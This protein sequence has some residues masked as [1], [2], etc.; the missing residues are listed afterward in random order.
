MDFPLEL[1]HLTT[2]QARAVLEGSST[3]VVLVPVGSTEPHGPHLPLS[4]DLIIS[5]EVCRRAASALRRELVAAFVAPVLPYGVTDFAAGF[6]GAISIPAATLTA[7]VRDLCRAYLRDGW[8][9]VSVVNNH[10][11][12]EH[13]A[14]LHAAV[15]EVNEQGGGVDGGGIV[16]CSLPNVLSRRWGRTLTEEFKRGACHAGRYEGSLVLAARPE[17][18]DVDVMKGLPEN[19][20][21][22]SD[23]IASG[24]QTFREIGGEEAYFG[25]PAEATAAEGEDT[26]ARLVE[27]VRCEVLEALGR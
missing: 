8:R 9:H 15:V 16:P 7:F 20:V 22:L 6:A 2:R 24:A 13:V 3:A 10:L 17:L 27:M 1:A 4:T 19:P 12:P 18:V 11:E 21:S 5:E 25:A 23:A 26:Y 14:A